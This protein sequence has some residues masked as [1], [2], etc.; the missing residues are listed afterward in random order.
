V[1]TVVRK[2][3]GKMNVPNG[4]G[5]LRKPPRPEAEAKLLN[6]SIGLLRGEAATGRKTSP[7]WPLLR[8]MRR[9]RMNW[10]PIYWA[11]KTLWSK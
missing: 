4:P 2:D 10:A 9:T 6:E 5:A 7:S 8:I 11:P 3:T 1:P